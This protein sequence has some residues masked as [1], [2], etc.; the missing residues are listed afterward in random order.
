MAPNAVQVSQVTNLQDAAS[1]QAVLFGKIL[2]PVPDDVTTSF[3]QQVLSRMNADETAKVVKN[4]PLIKQFGPR[5][6]DRKDVEE[7]TANIVG[8]RMW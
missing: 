3:Y 1:G 7:H 4:D 2:L 5:K 6:W 8:N